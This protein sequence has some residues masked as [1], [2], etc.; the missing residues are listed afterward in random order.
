METSAPERTSALEDAKD[1]LNPA[2]RR[3][4]PHGSRPPIVD[5]EYIRSGESA[6]EGL[7]RAQTFG[8]WLAEKK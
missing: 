5:D 4:R 2:R 1:L 8:A 7:D 3:V 6:S